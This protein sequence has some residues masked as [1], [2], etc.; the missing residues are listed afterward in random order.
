MAC[1]QLLASHLAGIVIRALYGVRYTDMCGYR[2]IRRD[3]LDRLGMQEMTYGWNIEMQ[4]KAARFG[5]AHSRTADALPV[6]L[7]AANP[8]WPNRSRFAARGMAHRCDLSAC[9]HRADARLAGISH[10]G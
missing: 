10:A 4:M 8:M 9:G 6:P 7:V 2:A 3:C 5:A 1:H